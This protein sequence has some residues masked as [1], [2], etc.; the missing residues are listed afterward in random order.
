MM[1]PH[2]A[3]SS[4]WKPRI[5]SVGITNGVVPPTDIVLCKATVLQ[6]AR[7]RWCSRCTVAGGVPAG[8]QAAI[9][10]GSSTPVAPDPARVGTVGRE[11]G[12][13][14]AGDREGMQ[15]TLNRRAAGVGVEHHRPARRDGD[16]L[17]AAHRVVR[18][19]PELMRMAREGHVARN[20]PQAA[21]ARGLADCSRSQDRT[22]PGARCRD[23]QGQLER[24]T[25]HAATARR[26]SE[27]AMISFM[28]SE[29]PP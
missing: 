5:A 22:R 16:R 26:Y 8:A 12:A 3:V 10:H 17:E 24:S 2:L 7:S 29:V 23:P 19:P 21:V 9:Q 25:D 13:A 27:R 11:R 1:A 4:A 15:S 14:G 6:T 28:I 20:Q 18:E